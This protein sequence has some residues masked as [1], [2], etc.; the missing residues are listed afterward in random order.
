VIDGK[1][2]VRSL[3]GEL[4]SLEA[5][6]GRDADNLARL[7][8]EWEEA[9]TGWRTAADFE[10]WLPERVTQVAVAWVL[11]TVFVRFAEDNDLIDAPFFA[12]PGIRLQLARER[13]QAYFRYYP[14]RTD[15]DWII[16]ALGALGTSPATV[17]MFDPLHALMARYPIS[18]NAAMQLL[19]FWRRTDE[20]GHLVLDFTDPEWS[21]RFLG[22]LYQDLSEGARKT[23]ALL[24]TPEFIEEFIL[25]HTLDPAIAEFGLEPDPPHGYPGLP[26]RLRVVDPACGS[27]PFLEGA[28]HRLLAAWEVERPGTDRWELIANALQ[29]VHGVD[30]YPIAAVISRFRLLIAAM[31]AGGARRISEVPDLPIVVAAGDSLI[32]GKA[33]VQSDLD[34]AGWEHSASERDFTLAGWDI[35]EF[36]T[37]DAGLLRSGSYHVVVCNPPYLAVQDPR[38]NQLYRQAYSTCRGMFPLTMPFLQRAFQLAVRD[39]QTSREPAGYVG[40]LVANSFMKREFGRTM[41]EEFL[42]TVDLTHVLDTSGVYIPGHGT[43]TV[44]LLGRRRFPER[45]S[46]VRTAIGVRGEPYPPTDPGAGLVWRAL[47]DQM[48]QP[49]STSEWI[50]VE[51]VNRGRF[52]KHPWSL[53]APSESDLLATLEK[54]TRLRDVVAR[55]G[56]GAATGSD[57][58]FLAPSRVFERRGA[59]PEA[60]VT[61]IRGTDVRDWG[62][63]PTE[64]AFMPDTTS[65][66]GTDDESFPRHLRRLWPLRTM[67]RERRYFGGETVTAHGRPFY[68]WHQ[69]A[70]TPGMHRWSIAFPAVATSPHFSVLREGLVP[71]QSAPMVKLPGTASDDE[72]FGLAAVLNSP[73]TSFYLKQYCQ[74][75]GAPSADQLRA[76]ER[77]GITYEFTPTRL[78][79]LPLPGELPAQRGAELDALAHELRSLRPTAA[80]MSVTV[81]TAADLDE[82]KAAYQHI[83]ARMIAVQ[84]ELDWEVYRQFGLLPNSEAAGLVAAPEIVPE[85]ALGERAFE[86][87]LARRMRDQGLETQW[88]ER[89][90]S[91]PI[92][93]IP[94]HWPDAYR[95]VVERRI[96]SIQTNRDFG[97]LEQPEHKRRWSSDPWDRLRDAALREWMLDR[98]EARDLWLDPDGQPRPMTVN[99]LADRLRADESVVAVA[100]LLRGQ[101]TSRTDLA[102]VLAEILAYEHVPFLAQYRYKGE[103]LLKRK[104][105]EHTWDL[106]RQQDASGGSRDIPVPPNYRSSDFA[107]PSYWRHRGKLDVPKERFISYPD[108]SP[109]SDGSLLLGWAGWDHRE[110]AQALYTVIEERE[111]IDRWRTDRLVPLVAGLAEVMPWIRQ[112]HSEVDPAFGLSPAEM[113][114]HYLALRERHALTEEAVHSWTAPPARRGRPPKKR[115]TGAKT[116]ETTRW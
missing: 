115:R 27:G 105:W 60:S 68:T 89:H 26:C 93:E 95:A 3:R 11:G 48:D 18:R 97:V 35:S 67:L 74:A 28:F 32:P 8:I 30:K 84:E 6:L 4:R 46:V 70:G 116:T 111:T 22:D 44:I 56:Y 16:D 99:G 86:I 71:L 69:V 57:D 113:F 81:P 76:D 43:P 73:V 110:Q 78:L 80:R 47:T 5:D 9:R 36:T 55:I 21:T 100:Q 65:R 83:R 61:V 77:W 7:R 103:G 59:E 92:T 106:Q 53:S 88:F 58:A 17:R 96:E 51:D 37:S 87:A 107:R 66:Q 10:A 25:R 31:R 1:Q 82:M 101:A 29:S 91:T 112:W 85:L 45:S 90:G 38:E 24:Q 63:E 108:A 42:P 109:D 94:E 23:Y 62:V 34:N 72:H 39:T 52:A 15:R 104:A 2:L 12:G 13:Q 54:G 50:S 40:V 41:V 64:S 14:T 98:C 75:K 49:G 19:S 102:E 20:A 79:D 114:D 33:G